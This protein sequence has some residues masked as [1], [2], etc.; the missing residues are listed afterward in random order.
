MAQ[1]DPFFELSGDPAKIGQDDFYAHLDQSNHL[2]DTIYE[3]ATLD[4]RDKRTTRLVDKTFERVSFSKT[5]IRNIIFRG[6]IFRDCLFIGS[7][8]ERCEFHGCSF[9]RTNVHKVSFEKTYIDPKCFKNCLDRNKYQNI[10]VHLYQSLMNNS[11]NTQQ[12]EF[13]ADARFYFLRW[14]RYQE[15][16]EV[17]IS[18][19][20]DKKTDIRKR[21][22]I[23]A[24]FFWEWLFGSGIRLRHFVA[25]A[26]GSVVLVSLFNFLLRERL[27]LSGGDEIIN[28]FIDSFYFST[29]TLSTLGFGDITP[30]TQL[31]RFVIAAQAVFGFFLFAMLASM[32]FRKIAP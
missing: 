11:R 30:T 15:L 1:N 21:A 23:S 5:T 32:I 27:G 8:I 3:P 13:E 25:T 6:C 26:L 16:Y 14:K 9:V 10:G 29:I 12:P 17:R 4:R 28:T 20:K 19:R 2:C 22:R 31:G 18:W 24:R 7:S